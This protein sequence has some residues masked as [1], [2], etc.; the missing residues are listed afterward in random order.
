MGI[1]W[2]QLNQYNNL[3]LS[4]WYTWVI[5]KTSWQLV[6]AL[7]TKNISKAIF[8][9][10]KVN[11][12]TKEDWIVEEIVWYLNEPKNDETFGSNE[13]YKLIGKESIK[14][15]QKLW[16]DLKRNVLSLTSKIYR[17]LPKD[18]SNQARNNTDN[19]KSLM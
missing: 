5:Q 11:K 14:D 6:D 18:N 3:R 9:V 12:I 2:N 15:I 17:L 10:Q 13:I 8:N 7:Q 19:V 1:E 16:L 4:M